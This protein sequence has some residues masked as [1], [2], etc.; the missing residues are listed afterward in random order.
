MS[1]SLIAVAFNLARRLVTTEKAEAPNS[2]R[3]SER[4]V[5]AIKPAAAYDNDGVDLPIFLHK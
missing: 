3:T 4:P 1:S 2:H 5:G